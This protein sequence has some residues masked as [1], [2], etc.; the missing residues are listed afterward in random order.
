MM[1][2][3]FFNYPALFAREESELMAIVHD[4]L[5]R[6]AYVMQK[7]LTEFEENQYFPIPK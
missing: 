6:G 5:R 4:V 2:I 1:Q 3:P 7:D